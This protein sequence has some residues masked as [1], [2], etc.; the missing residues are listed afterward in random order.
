MRAANGTGAERA[1]SKRIR[2]AITAL[3]AV[4]A[5]RFEELLSQAQAD[6]DEAFEFLQEQGA[7]DLLEVLIAST[8]KVDRLQ[9]CASDAADAAEKGGE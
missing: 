7:N 5:R 6:L 9:N 8:K 3:G 1:T 4:N 2:Q